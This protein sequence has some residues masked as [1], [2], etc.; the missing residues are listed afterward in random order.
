MLQSQDESSLPQYYTF[1]CEETPSGPWEKTRGEEMYLSKMAKLN[2]YDTRKE[3]KKYQAVLEGRDLPFRKEQHQAN[4]LKH[5][6]RAMGKIKRERMLD[7]ISK[8]PHKV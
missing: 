2:I 7:K 8:M 5:Y 3:M 6:E 4:P 1:A